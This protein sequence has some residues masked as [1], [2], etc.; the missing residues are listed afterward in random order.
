MATLRAAKIALVA[1]DFVVARE[2]NRACSLTPPQPDGARSCDMATLRA[3]KIA[4]VAVDF[5]VARERNGRCSLT[6]PQPD[7]ARSCDMATLRAAKIAHLGWAIVSM[8]GRRH[9][10]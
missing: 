4:L 1:V 3:A 7:G 8:P 5:V 6:P 10:I 9:S 2:R